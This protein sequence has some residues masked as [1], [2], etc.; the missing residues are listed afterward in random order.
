[1]TPTVTVR[2]RVRRIEARG[3]PAL[4]IKLYTGSTRDARSDGYWSNLIT[5]P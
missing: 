1:M 3:S 4:R 5:D 2:E